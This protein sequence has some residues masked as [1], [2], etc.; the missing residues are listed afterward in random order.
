MLVGHVYCKTAV[1]SSLGSPLTC[2]QNI[3]HEGLTYGKG[4]ESGKYYH[5]K[6]DVGG[7][8]VIPVYMYFTKRWQH[9]CIYQAPSV[10]LH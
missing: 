10:S 7:C 9:W 3:M 2:A 6:V 8:H 1:V 5:V 4:R